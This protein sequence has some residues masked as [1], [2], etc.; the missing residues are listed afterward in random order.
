MA[1][2][3]L[4]PNCG[5]TLDPG[6]KCDCQSEKIQKWESMNRLLRMEKTGQVALAFGEMEGSYGKES[7]Y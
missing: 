5:G 4:C 7:S 2:Y 3:R 1:Y 6:E